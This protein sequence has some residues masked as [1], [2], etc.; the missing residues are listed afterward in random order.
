[1]GRLMGTIIEDQRFN[2]SFL[3][4]MIWPTNGENSAT[5]SRPLALPQIPKGNVSQ[6]KQ[7]WQL[8]GLYGA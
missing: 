5:I 2:I 4:T 1:M 3:P 6:H 8:A 7:T